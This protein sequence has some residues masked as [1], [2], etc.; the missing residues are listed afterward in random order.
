MTKPKDDFQIAVVP[1]VEIPDGAKA[2]RRRVPKRPLDI[3]IGLLTRGE[4][5]LTRSI[6]LGE[7]GMTVYSAKKM[8]AGYRV[9]ITLR[10]PDVLNGILMARVAQVTPPESANGDSICVLEFVDLDF[11]IK[12]KIRNFVASGKA[13]MPG[14][15]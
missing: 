3:R 5:F 13:N 11:G 8:E 10:I 2:P 14:V 12:R 6:D 4:Y 15:A 7:E 9:A 1:K